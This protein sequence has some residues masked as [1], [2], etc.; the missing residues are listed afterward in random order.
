[1]SISGTDV[2]TPEAF[3]ISRLIRE[4]IFEDIMKSAANAP[5]PKIKNPAVTVTKIIYFLFN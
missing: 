1:M 2:F 5:H 3:G 4:E